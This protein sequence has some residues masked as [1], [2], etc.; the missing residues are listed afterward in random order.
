MSP[1]F[2]IAPVKK[3]LSKYVL[4]YIKNERIIDDLIT[5]DILS[6]NKKTFNYSIAGENLTRDKLYKQED[7]LSIVGKIENGITITANFK[8]FSN[9]KQR[10]FRILDRVSSLFKH[11]IMCLSLQNVYNGNKTY[12]HHNYKNNVLINRLYPTIEQLNSVMKSISSNKEL[13]ENSKEL[14][15]AI[16]ISILRYKKRI[17]K[18]HN[19]PV[20]ISS[21]TANYEEQYY[22]H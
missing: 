20:N 22:Y 7:L 12:H 10:L 11:P 17:L 5:L 18:L 8:A 4:D 6:N 19:Q 16:N 1:T 21:W 14:E 2:R 15:D 3:E 13:K 9:D